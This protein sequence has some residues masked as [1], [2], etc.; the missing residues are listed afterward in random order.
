MRNTTA[1]RA[2]LA[3]MAGAIGATLLAGAVG[4]KEP[5]TPPAPPTSSYCPQEDDPGWRANQTCGNSNGH[6]SR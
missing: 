4:C 5:T 6:W 1:R 2:V 3:L